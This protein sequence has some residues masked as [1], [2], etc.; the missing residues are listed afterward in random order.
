MLPSDPSQLAIA[1][2]LAV[3]AAETHLW[4]TWVTTWLCRHS[5]HIYT[6]AKV[7]C[8]Q[9]RVAGKSLVLMQILFDCTFTSFFGMFSYVNIISL[10]L[11]FLACSPMLTY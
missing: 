10:L 1:V 8:F 9:T 2:A 6:R 3:W 7:D 4:V 11:H 5:T